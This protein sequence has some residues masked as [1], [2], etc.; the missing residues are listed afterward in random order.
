MLVKHGLD[1]LAGSFQKLA[2]A[3]TQEMSREAHK[4]KGTAG[5]LGMARVS[6]TAARLEDACRAGEPADKLVNELAA[7][8]SATRDAL[9]VERILSDGATHGAIDAPGLPRP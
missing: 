4:M 8:M 3:S 7:A 9:V 1:S 5:T 2:G 6:K